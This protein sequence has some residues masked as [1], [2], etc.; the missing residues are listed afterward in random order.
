M[1]QL[2]LLATLLVSAAFSDISASKEIQNESSKTK[3][4]D[5]VVEGMVYCQSC[6][7]LGSWSLTGAKP[8]S[9]AKVGVI[10]ENSMNRVSYYKTFQTD[11]QGY[12][13]AELDGYKMN[14]SLLDHPLQACHVKLISSPLASCDVLTNVNYGINGASL[15]YENKRLV[16]ENMK[17]EA[18]IY[19][20]APL[21]FRPAQCT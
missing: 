17:Y 1:I 10:C 7:K 5:V 6:N 16:Y 21:A 18:L 3:V 12:F 19:A 20:S 13:Y 8:L 15:H 14:H 2:A 9:G 11:S 4:I